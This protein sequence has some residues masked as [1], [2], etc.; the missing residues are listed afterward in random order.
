MNLQSRLQTK[1]WAFFD[2]CIH[3]MA[4]VPKFPL[5][6]H[7]NIQT[8]TKAPDTIRTP[9]TNNIA[10]RTCEDTELLTRECCEG[11]EKNLSVAAQPT[12]GM[13]HSID[14][15]CSVAYRYRQDTKCCQ[16]KYRH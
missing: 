2:I 15:S 11:H 14:M 10:P 8:P 4:A 9:N 3:I 5:N 7:Q 16:R 13:I 12:D 6:E 1:R